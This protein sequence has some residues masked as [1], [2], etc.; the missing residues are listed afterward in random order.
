[1]TIMTRLIGVL[2][3]LGCVSITVGVALVWSI[4]GACI[5]TGSIAV[6][7]AVLLYDP[8]AAT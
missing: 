5:V 3:L 7:A 6:A 4:G 2:A 1:M 8:K